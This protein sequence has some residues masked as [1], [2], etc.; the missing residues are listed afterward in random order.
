MKDIVVKDFN[1]FLDMASQIETPFKFYAEGP[2]PEDMRAW[3]WMRT[4]LLS[5]EGET[6]DKARIKLFEHGFM[7]A[8]ERET[9]KGFLE[10]LM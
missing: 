9:K 2:A 5:F 7:E 6:S 8:E 1:R 4:F 10:D 3:I